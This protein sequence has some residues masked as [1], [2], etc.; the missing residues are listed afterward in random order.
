MSRTKVESHTRELSMCRDQKS[1][2]CSLSAWPW[3]VAA[4][5][6]PECQWVNL[7][8]DEIEDLRRRVVERDAG[9]AEDYP[10][11]LFQCVDRG[12]EH[13]RSPL[14]EEQIVPLP[15]GPEQHFRYIRFYFDGM[16]AWFF[17]ARARPFLPELLSLMLAHAG[18]TFVMT[19]WFS[20]TRTAENLLEVAQD[21]AR[22]RTNPGMSQ[23]TTASAVH[24][25]LA[26]DNAGDRKDPF[27]VR[28]PRRVRK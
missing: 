8:P 17:L 9:A 22:R 13:N 21:Y 6:R 19:Q 15:E 27:G 26:G 28:T 4:S 25:A 12:P 2:G 1:F 14:L 18:A 10:V 3:R 16:T 7:N 5:S 23:T 20:K 24:R 11:Q